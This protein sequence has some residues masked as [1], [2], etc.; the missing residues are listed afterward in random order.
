M[1]RT[2]LASIIAVFVAAFVLFNYSTPV[3]GQ[4][5]NAERPRAAGQATPTPTPPK[6]KKEE[7]E[8]LR[9]DTELVNLNIRVVDR[10]GRPL[11]GVKQGEF[12]IFEDNV[13]QQIEFFSFSEVP[14]NYGIVVD[15]S[16]SLRSQLEKV[17]EAGKILIATNKPADESLIIRFVSRDK[18]TI[19]QNFTSNKTDLND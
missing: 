17:V 13:P 9:V 19:E 2:S 16:G 6:I 18:I 12:K 10:N 3:E 14:T 4:P 1:S 11:V 15:N 7:D 5:G 8:I